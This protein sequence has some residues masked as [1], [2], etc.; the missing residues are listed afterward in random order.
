MKFFPERSALYF[1]LPLFVGVV[2]GVC[3]LYAI[4]WDFS[5]EDKFEELALGQENT[6]YYA[7]VDQAQ[8]HCADLTDVHQCIYDYNKINSAENVVLW[9]G[10]SQL[11]AINQKN[12]GDLTA[13]A[14]LHREAKTES[15]YILTFSQ[16]NANLQEHYLLFEYISNKVPVTIL[17]LPV[18]FDDMRE[19]GIRPN[20]IEAFNNQKVSFHL[21]KTKIG[22]KLVSE[23]GNQDAAGND[24][25]ALEDTVQEKSEK[26]LNDEM[27][28][29]WSIW[30][31]RAELRGR[32]F[33]NLYFFRNWLFGINPSSIRKI[34]S[35]RYRMNLDALR[36]VFQ[37][38]NDK[39]IKVL[40]YIPPLRNDVKVPYELDQYGKFKT[41]I[42]LLTQQ[43]G[44]K[45]LNLE[46]LVPAELWGTKD[47]TTLGMGQ[48]LDFM[49]FQAG[50]HE[51][52]ANTL[53]GELKA[54]WGEETNN[55]F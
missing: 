7:T 20:L 33:T 44:A 30:E 31:R 45:F 51:L 25:A 10:N 53:Y 9:L 55:G 49:H 12:P 43:N 24:F 28:E 15:K 32:F 26:Y 36:A 3:T 54:L 52:L 48:E 16:P 23:N 50:G 46:R 47:S 5:S 19:T 27:N 38:A 41:E 17:I 4:T 1:S 39:G 14:I 42:K 21:K 40:L 35:G 34:I 6:S 11:H 18:V 2:L 22:R 13:S 8:V 37:S 29:I